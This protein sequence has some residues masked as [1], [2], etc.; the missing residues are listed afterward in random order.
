LGLFAHQLFDPVYYRSKLNDLEATQCD[1]EGAF[2]HFLRQ[3]PFDKNEKPT[4]IYFYPDWYLE[5]Y[6]E[7]AGQIGH[8]WSCALNHYLSNSTPTQFDPLPEFSESCY[9][10]RYTDVATTV[11]EGK[12]RNGYYHFLNNGAFEL[13]SPN[14]TIDLRSYVSRCGLFSS[15][16]PADCAINPFGH[17]LAFVE[18]VGLKRTP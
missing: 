12:L 18:A 7:I 10:T 5:R 8:Q 14:E 16:A 4:S 6:R 17:L 15:V 1:Q 3:I 13:R 11:A 9:L 2:H